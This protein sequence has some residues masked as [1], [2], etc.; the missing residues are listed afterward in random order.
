MPEKN[1]AVKRCGGQNKKSQRQGIDF[2]EQK[3]FGWSVRKTHRPVATHPVT[4]LILR[5]G[6]LKT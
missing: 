5:P 1:D 3:I 4:R 6:I 2:D